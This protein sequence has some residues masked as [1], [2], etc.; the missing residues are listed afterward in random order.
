MKLSPVQALWLALFI[1]AGSPIAGKFSVGYM[2]P[3]FI[4]LAGTLTT[5]ALYA[6]WLT[7]HKMWGRLVDKD[8]RFR[9]SVMGLFGTALPFMLLLLALRWTTPSNSAIL[10]QAESVYSL[11]FAFLF[12]RERPSLK[13]IAGTVMVVAGA[14]LILAVNGYTPMWKGDLIVIGTVW[15]FQ[16]SHIAAKKLPADISVDFITAARGFYGFLWSA[17]LALAA[18]PLGME[19][20]FKPSAVSVAALFYIAV[21]VYTLRNK[22]WYQAI[23]NM[24][25]AK[26]TAVILSYPVFT[27][28]L[29]VATGFDKIQLYQA[30][31]LAL[32]LGGAYMVTLAKR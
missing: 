24:P 6:P 8:I 25:L 30:A 18:L 3:S 20:S 11:I 28:I 26:A 31:G 9:L 5:L 2:S 14:V 12:L 16:V 1:T 4:L 23:R 21:F 13:Q 22:F 32:A 7:K 10:N 17:V 19:I 15:M 29:S 27:Y